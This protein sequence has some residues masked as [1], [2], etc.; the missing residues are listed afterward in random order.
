M[1]YSNKQAFPKLSL[2]FFKRNLRLFSGIQNLPGNILFVYL[3]V[4]IILIS[5]SACEKTD[6]GTIDDSGLPPHILLATLSPTLINVDSLP[7]P[8]GTSTIT[9]T[10]NATLGDP[11]G[12]I[13]LNTVSAEIFRPEATSP[14][15]RSTLRDDGVV[16]DAI[17]NDGNF[18]G[19]LTFQATRALAGEYR[20]SIKAENRDGKRGGAFICS[21]SLTRNNS[22]PF[23]N[24]ATL[25]APDTLTRPSTGSVL[26]MITIAASD[27]DGLADIRQ[28]YL[29]NLA[30]SNRDFLLDD[31]GTTQP[32]GISSG[33]ALAGDGVFSILLQLPSTVPPGEYH[34]ILQASDSFAD[35]SNSVPYTLVVQ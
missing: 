34:Y 22:R 1:V 23:L 4:L 5:V 20:V 31:G 17:P 9:I 33:D 15:L 2:P 10:V 27:S 26:F 18:T 7:S 14:F 13:E 35:T 21:M 12:L 16:P 3:P 24:S 19:S 29:Q 11:A 25:S 28:L 6:L 8:G 32:N 30:S